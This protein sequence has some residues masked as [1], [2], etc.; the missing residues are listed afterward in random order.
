MNGFGFVPV[1]M[2]HFDMDPEANLLKKKIF[3]MLPGIGNGELLQLPE[4]VVTSAHAGWPCPSS[5]FA[6]TQ[7][8]PRI[9]FW[10]CGP[11]AFFVCESFLALC[12]CMVL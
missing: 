10:F 5:S 3:P 8:L 7:Y 4:L 2:A 11:A 1:T 6:H 12:L 9:P